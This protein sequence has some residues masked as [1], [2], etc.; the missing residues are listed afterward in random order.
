MITCFTLLGRSLHSVPLR[1]RVA[2][3]ACLSVP[4]SLGAEIVLDVRTNG[5]G[6]VVLDKPVSRATLAAEQAKLP[7]TRP[8]PESPPGSA[9]WVSLPDGTR[10]AV[11]WDVTRA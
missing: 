11:D 4:V 10:A 8:T 6:L 7:P 3:L 1:F 5:F 9:L 2:M